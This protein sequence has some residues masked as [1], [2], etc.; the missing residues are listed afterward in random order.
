MPEPLL[1][2]LARVS[3]PAVLSLVT[4][5]LQCDSFLYPAGSAAEMMP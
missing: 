4:A 1:G 5:Q 2:S 3:R